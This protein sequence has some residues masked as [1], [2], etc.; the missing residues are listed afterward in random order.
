MRL[1]FGLKVL[2][3]LIGL[4][5]A[6]VTSSCEKYVTHNKAERILMRDTWRVQ[7]CVINNNEEA[8]L[9]LGKSLKFDE[10]DR[11]LV[12]NA[13]SDVHG[14]WV[15]GLNRK[16]C[17]LYIDAM[18]N[19]PYSYLNDD[20]EILTNARSTVTLQSVNGSVTNTMT[21]TRIEEN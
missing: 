11:L 4:S 7:S 18:Q 10:S 17:H 13:G 8:T 6:L 1:N 16:P 21:L 15:V 9:F 12:N 3:V 20:W 5:S 2:T 19:I 14:K